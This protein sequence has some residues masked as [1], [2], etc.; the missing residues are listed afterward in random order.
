M[1]R[2]EFKCQ[3]CFDSGSTLN[4]HHKTYTKGA[5]PWEY[6]E[7]NFV[8]L[9]ESCHKSN[10]E[11]IETIKH[12]IFAPFMHDVLYELMNNEYFDEFCNSALMYAQQYNNPDQR[13]YFNNRLRQSM[14][15]CI[16][17][18]EL[19]RKEKSDE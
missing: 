7:E 5:E 15:Y 4:V 17:R 12:R 11:L 16:E 8:T 10:H 2:D 19:E 6:D 9:C 13:Q 14:Q 3:N 1:Q 18:I